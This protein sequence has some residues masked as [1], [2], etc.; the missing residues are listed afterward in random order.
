VERGGSKKDS[1][2]QRTRG[3]GYK[4]LSRDRE[5]RKDKRRSTTY[6]VNKM[7]FIREGSCECA[8]SEL[9]L[10]SVPATQTAIESG[11]YVEYH[12]ISS[13]IGGA[14][15]EFDVNAS[16]DDYLDL[17]NSFLCV[18][19]KITRDNGNDL[20]W[21]TPSDRSTISPQS[22]LASRRVVKRH[23]NYEFDEYITAC[24][25]VQSKLL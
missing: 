25:L 22:V 20:E 10:F 1:G 9:D 24:T 5:K 21:L 13:L 17:S 7:A 3:R 6:S 23:A 19:A 14:P 11:I 2:S 8:K 16:G 15:I 4:G 12:P 18:R